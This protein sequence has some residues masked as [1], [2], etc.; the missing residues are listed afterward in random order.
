MAVQFSKSGQVVDNSIQDLWSKVDPK[1]KGKFEQN[2]KDTSQLIQTTQ[3]PF[4]P[5]DISNYANMM[6]NLPEYQDMTRESATNVNMRDAV[7][8]LPVSERSGWVAPLAALTDQWTKSKL[9]GSVPKIQG[10]SELLLGLQ[11]K[12]D[13]DKKNQLNTILSSMDK[14]KA[15]TTGLTT[16]SSLA[17][18][19]APPPKGTGKAE[20][21]YIKKYLE[22]AG[23]TTGK[24][25]TETDNMIQSL[26]KNATSLYEMKDDKLSPFG[27][28]GAFASAINKAGFN[29]KIKSTMDK[30]NSV[31]VRA[32]SQY[33]KGAMSEKDRDLIIS[34]IT[35]MGGDPETF[36]ENVQIT[37]N[38]LKASAEKEKKKRMILSK[39]GMPED[40][41]MSNLAIDEKYNNSPQEKK[42]SKR[43]YSP[44]RNQTRITYSDGTT[45]VVSGKK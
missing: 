45:E 8:N 29:P 21:P 22:S 15:G 40:V 23:T 44:S 13:Q 32:E 25:D 3:T 43:Q 18:G 14:F 17:I 12:V 31:A 41:E 39:G 33:Q 42:V 1:L 34:S 11:N 37:I 26:E 36:K 2:L 35:S 28:G 16:G 4:N 7:A 9:A 20:S 10:N 19:D 30:L 38:A 27:F 6:R 5:E 24:T